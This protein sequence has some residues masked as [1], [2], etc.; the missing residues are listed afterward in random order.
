LMLWLPP[1]HSRSPKQVCCGPASTQHLTTPCRQG[2]GGILGVIWVDIFSKPSHLLALGFNAD[3]PGLFL[4]G[5][6]SL[7]GTQIV[8]L[9][10]IM[11]VAYFL[12]I[13][14]CKVEIGDMVCYSIPFESEYCVRLNIFLP[15][16]F[17]R[18]GT[19]FHGFCNTVG[20]LGVPGSHNP[21]RK[22]A[23]VEK[24]RRTQCDTGH[25]PSR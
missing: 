3:Y 5:G 4:G 13:K 23:R 6:F 21:H 7:L 16:G 22:S 2:C 8:G 1:G 14:F 10:Y 17:S 15:K 25:G 24:Y 11:S 18:F 20:D 19:A 12:P 9:L